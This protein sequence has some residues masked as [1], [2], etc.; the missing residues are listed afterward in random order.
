MV[1][2]YM[3]VKVVMEVELLIKVMVSQVLVLRIRLQ[4]H[5]V[6]HLT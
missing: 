1:T 5:E 4:E 6:L 2:K 3:M